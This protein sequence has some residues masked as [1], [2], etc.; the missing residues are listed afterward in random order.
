VVRGREGPSRGGPMRGRSV[1]FYFRFAKIKLVLIFLFSLCYDTPIERVLHGVSQS[2]FIL[3]AMSY[4]APTGAS[5]CD[6]VLVQIVL[7]HF[8]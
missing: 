5:H 6:T 8:E 7:I 3:R 4:W 2:E 1:C